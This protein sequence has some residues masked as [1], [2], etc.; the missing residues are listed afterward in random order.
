MPLFLGLGGVFRQLDG[1]KHEQQALRLGLSLG[2]TQ[3]VGER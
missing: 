1:N 2:G 3:Q